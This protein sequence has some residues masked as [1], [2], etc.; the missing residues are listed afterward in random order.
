M[1]RRDFL[2]RLDKIL[3]SQGYGSRKEI[4]K[5]IRDG[6]VALDGLAIT[7]PAAKV[8]PDTSKIYVDGKPVIYRKY[9]YII[10]NK[11]AGVLCA[12]E[13]RKERTVLDI[14]PKEMLVPKL[15]PAGRL[16]KDSTGLLL[17]TNDGEF[18][19]RMLSPK[20]GVKKRYLVKLCRAA[21]DED[22]EIFAKGISEGGENF[23]PAI[24]I[25]KEKNFAQVEISEGKFHEVKRLFA[26][27][28]NTV[29]SLE[30]ISIG[31]LKLPPDLKAGDARIISNEEAMKVFL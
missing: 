10:M 9:T 25:P 22:I 27:T 7:D 19:H 5:I 8:D 3:A 4:S 16:D 23:A 2:E 31:E 12:T 20:S 28:G 30:R 26:F 6:R 17:I 1:T 21:T 15:F 14:L 24:L 18:A 11:P 13:D 29:L